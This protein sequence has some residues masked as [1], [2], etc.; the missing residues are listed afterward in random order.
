MSTPQTTIVLSTGEELEV[1]GSLDEVVKALENAA[2]SSFGTLAQLVSATDGT[3]AVNPSHVMVV[4][5]A[6]SS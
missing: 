2:R 6:G 5:P 1:E 3:I 4:R